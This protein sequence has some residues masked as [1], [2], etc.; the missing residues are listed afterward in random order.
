V[1]QVVAAIAV[2]IAFGLIFA[3]GEW[4]FRVLEHRLDSRLHGG[5]RWLTLPI[6]AVL[7]F[8]GFLALRPW[9]LDQP[10][11]PL[12][13]GLGLIAIAL[14]VGGS[15]ALGYAAVA[16]GRWFGSFVRGR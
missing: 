6:T 12:W 13:F 3:A 10:R 14:L 2:V 9:I 5:W 16:V 4:M 15:T 7:C 11:T 1:D 8:A